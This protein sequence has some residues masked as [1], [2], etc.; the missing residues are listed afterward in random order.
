M[1]GILKMLV[2]LLEKVFVEHFLQHHFH[3][4][5]LEHIVLLDL[6]LLSSEDELYSGLLL[7]SRH[8]LHALQGSHNLHLF[9]VL[10]AIEH[11]VNESVWRFVHWKIELR[12]VHS[13]TFYNSLLHFEQGGFHHVFSEA[14]FHGLVFSH[15]FCIFFIPNM[16]SPARAT[17]TQIKIMKDLMML[18]WYVCCIIYIWQDDSMGNSNKTT[19]STRLSQFDYPM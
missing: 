19:V 16:S 6:L 10:V 7:L 13:C 18:W 12:H 1:G 17:P 4:H 3:H 14:R 11:G 5:F 9:H 15:C 2:L 8:L